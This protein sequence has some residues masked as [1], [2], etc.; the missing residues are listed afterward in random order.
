MEKE[1][2]L[3]IWFFVGVL[4]TV[5]GIIVSAAEAIDFFAPKNKQADIVL[6]NLH[7]GLWWGA[8]LFILGLVFLIKHRPGKKKTT[9]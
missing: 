7:A 1:S 8:V 9:P 2:K 6:E 3:S 4:L 5:Y